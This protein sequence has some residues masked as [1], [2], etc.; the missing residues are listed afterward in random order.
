MPGVGLHGD[1]LVR[2]PDHPIEALSRPKVAGLGIAAQPADDLEQHR[3]AQFP[4]DPT[5]SL[6]PATEDKVIPVD[7]A[8]IWRFGR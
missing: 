1:P 3:L 4:S 2:P 8:R 5:Q 6:R 7:K